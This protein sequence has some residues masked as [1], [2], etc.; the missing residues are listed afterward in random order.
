VDDPEY[1]KDL[2][3][4]LEC[5]DDLVNRAFSTPLLTNCG[6]EGCFKDGNGATI[7]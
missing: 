4:E 7:P 6:S 2:V 1:L 3:S 5:E